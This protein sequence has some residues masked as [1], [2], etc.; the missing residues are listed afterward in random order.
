MCVCAVRLQSLHAEAGAY[1][2]RSFRAEGWSL[3]AVR[4]SVGLLHAELGQSVD[5]LRAK[6]EAERRSARGA[7]AWRLEQVGG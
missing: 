7:G 6:L 1:C 3:E 2:V 5:L 4:Q